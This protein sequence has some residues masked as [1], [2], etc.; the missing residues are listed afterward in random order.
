MWRQLSALEARLLRENEARSFDDLRLPQR[1]FNAFLAAH[2]DAEL[3]S[4][5]VRPAE[6]GAGGVH[7]SALRGEAAGLLAALTE[8]LPT[9]DDE[10]LHAA[11][12]AHYGGANS[13]VAPSALSLPALRKQ[14][15]PSVPSLPA[16]CVLAAPFGGGGGSSP[17]GELQLEHAV[18]A[19]REA[20]P[21]EDLEEST[22]W[23]Q[24]FEPFLGGLRSFCK[25]SPE[26]SPRPTRQ[27]RPVSSPASS[28]GHLL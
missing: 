18:R 24:L 7:S 11:L 21:L 23:S 5:L 6:E 28:T 19:I 4:R 3:L 2:A 12:A 16:A 22:L 20:P 10:E 25:G 14:R 15:P 27:P 9:A 8:A 26:V 13:S 17:L 1:S